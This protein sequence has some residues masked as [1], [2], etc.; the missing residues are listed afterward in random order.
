MCVF[1]KTLLPQTQLCVVLL[2]W[3]VPTKLSHFTIYLEGPRA[4]PC[5]ATWIGGDA[6]LP[7]DI[8]LSFFL[9]S[10]KFKKKIH[11]P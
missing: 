7:P 1:E 11:S 3:D 4:P 5:G 10:A 9:K 6:H 8:Y 2:F